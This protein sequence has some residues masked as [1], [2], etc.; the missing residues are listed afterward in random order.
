MK[1]KAFAQ[2]MSGFLLS[3]IKNA[4]AA[5]FLWKQLILDD[6]NYNAFLHLIIR[7]S[8]LQSGIDQSSTIKQSAA[9]IVK[10][11]TDLHFDRQNFLF[12]TS[13][14]HSPV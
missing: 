3:H 9:A 8:G 5:D 13:L 11:M 10:K 6:G 14:M 1:F 7:L 12:V 4:V 2:A